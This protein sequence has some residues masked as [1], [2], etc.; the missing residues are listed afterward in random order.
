[1]EMSD[2]ALNRRQHD[3]ASVDALCAKYRTWG[4]WGADDE[5]GAANLVTP[6]RI[7]RAMQG[8]RR[9]QAFSL[10]L[11]LDRS[12]PQTGRTPRVN[13]QHL[14]L[15]I[16]AEPMGIGDGRQTA[17]DDAVYMPLQAA[18][19]WDAFCHMFQDGRT[20]NDRGAETVTARDGAKFNSITNF[21]DRAL[22]R[23][24]LLDIPRHLGRPA[25]EPGE[26][27]QAED[28]ERC[29]AAQGVEVRE[30]DFLLVRT[31]QLAQCR[32]DG[33]WGSYAGGPAPGLGVASADFI[34]GRGVV[35]VA[36]DTWGIEALPYEAPDI[37]APLHII[38]L[39]NAGVYIGEM[40]DMEALA[41]DCA[42]D[43]IFDFFLCAQ[44]LTVTGSVGSPL[45]PIAIK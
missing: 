44:P 2:P 22:G 1:M 23:G 9:G 28:L 21:K 42:E 30:G 32:A 20:Y 19:Q 24:V 37:L 7:L 33:E 43:G 39:V 36:T 14:M 3:A 38:L 45:N 4:R 11:P 29:A 34:C 17:S 10:A 16:P 18:T 35:G 13:P 40:W 5:L 15:R 31:G 25:L 12:G 27:I 8:V 6:E 26:S 41:A